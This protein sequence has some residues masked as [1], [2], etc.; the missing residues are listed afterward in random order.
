MSRAL[1]PLCIALILASCTS[2]G[3][4]EA[5]PMASGRVESVTGHWT[6]LGSTPLADMVTGLRVSGADNALTGSLYLSGRVLE[7]A[8]SYDGERLVMRFPSGGNSFELRGTV[9]DGSV[10]AVEVIAPG[11]TTPRRVRLSRVRPTG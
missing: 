10:L 2:E 9:E 6:N 11:A 5:S 1:L 7:G 3:A 8:G 4:D